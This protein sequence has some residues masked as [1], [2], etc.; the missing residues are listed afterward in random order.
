MS[1]GFLEAYLY[2]STF[3]MNF[4]NSIKLYHLLKVFEKFISLFSHI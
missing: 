4:K 3:L 2:R 1:K